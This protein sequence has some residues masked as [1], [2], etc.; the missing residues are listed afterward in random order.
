MEPSHNKV[1]PC[2][3]CAPAPLSARY[4]ARSSSC[5][6]HVASS[7]TV[8]D[9]SQ[10]QKHFGPANAYTHSTLAVKPFNAAHAAATR[11]EHW[12]AISQGTMCALSMMTGKNGL[13]PSGWGKTAHSHSMCY[14]Q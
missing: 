4:W 14:R 1:A 13:T 8:H 3:H 2:C 10:L 11:V 9:T 12:W 6:P 7:N 5:K